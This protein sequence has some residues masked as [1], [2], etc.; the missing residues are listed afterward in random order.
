[1][2]TQANAFF[3]AL[4]RISSS[5]IGPESR[6]WP[7]WLLTMVLICFLLFLRRRTVGSFFKW[8]FPVD[9]YFHKSHFVDIK[10]FFT[11]R[12]LS[13]FGM[14]NGFATTVFVATMVMSFLGGKHAPDA[15]MNPLLIALLIVLANDFGVYW[16]HRIHHETKSL[17]PFHAVHHS[18]E[19]LTPV[20]V[21]RK[22]PFYDVISA[23]VRG[24]LMGLLTGVLLALFVGKVH[25]A[26]I[27]GVNAVYAIFNFVG[28]NLRHT[29]IWLSYGRF[30]E[31]ILISPAQ[32]QIHHS[33]AVEHH[34][35][36]YGEVFAFWDWMFGTLYVPE[37]R[38]VLEF[39]VADEHGERLP[40]RHDSLTNAL[41]NPIV[42]SWNSITDRE[43]QS[44]TTSEQT[45]HD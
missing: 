25:V 37:K 5:I 1:M 39:G 44:A 43:L 28:S 11:G 30:L 15:T 42:D 6:L 3:D 33:L 26:M 36:N 32:H 13:L 35:K 7:M 21:Y 2:S 41:I 27:A 20:T 17:W 14:F 45:N 9:V 4:N 8:V 22:H 19:V 10:L 29:H 38:E 23:F 18:A 34:N 16:V 24:V 12:F 31:H 40:Q